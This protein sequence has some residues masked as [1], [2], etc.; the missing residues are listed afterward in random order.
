MWSLDYA[1][2]C[3]LDRDNPTSDM[4]LDYMTSERPFQPYFYDQPSQFLVAL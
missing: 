3:G 1:F 2:V 4:G